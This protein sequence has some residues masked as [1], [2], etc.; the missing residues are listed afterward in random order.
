MQLMH[1]MDF[2]VVPSRFEGFGL[3][4][5]EAMAMGK[6]L[7]V[8]DNFGLTELVDHHENGLIFETNN[9]SHLAASILKLMQSDKLQEELGIKAKLKAQEKFDI[10]VFRQ[11]IKFLYH[12]N[13]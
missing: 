10:S 1:L 12:L 2:V 7:I 13:E 5:A 6:P 11:G 9:V 8:A 4:A 3:T